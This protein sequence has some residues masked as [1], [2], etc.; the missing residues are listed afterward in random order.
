MTLTR[1]G[2]GRAPIL[3]RRASKG[4]S[5]A[6]AV[7]IPDTR[8]STDASGGSPRNFNV[9]WRVDRSTSLT[10]A[11]VARSSRAKPSRVGGATRSALRNARNVTAGGWEAA[12]K[13]SR[14]PPEGPRGGVE[15]GGDVPLRDGHQGEAQGLPFRD[16]QL[17]RDRVHPQRFLGLEHPRQG[18]QVPMA[19]RETEPH[20][21]E[22]AARD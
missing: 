5:P 16:A 19:A 14:P 12:V 11:F 21:R 17:R 8:P 2:S 22:E 7:A 6:T 3:R 15:G 9:R 4:P 1:R 20:Q 18:L 10:G 13:P